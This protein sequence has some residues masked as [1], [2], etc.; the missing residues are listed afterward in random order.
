VQT[1]LVSDVGGLA[2]Q[3][4]TNLVNSWG[5]TL[6][7]QGNVRITANGTGLSTLYATDGTILPQVVTIPPPGGSPPDTTAAPNGIVLTT[8]D[9]FIGPNQPLSPGSFVFA[10]EDGTLSAWGPDFNTNTAVLTVD[11]SASN[12]VYKGLALGTN[13]QGTFLYATNFRLG[14]VDVFDQNF[15]QVQL[16]GSFSDPQLPPP[17]PGSP[18]F[19]P[20]GI[21]NIGGNLYVTYALQK[22][23]QH[24]DQAG[25]GNGFVDVFDTDGN[26]LSRFASNGTL[27][28]PWGVAQAP[29]SFGMFSGALLV[30]N[31]GDGL[32]NA[33]DPTT[34]AF[35]GQLADPNSQPI[36]IEGLWGI[37]FQQSTLFFAAGINGEADG[38]M[39][40]LNTV[41]A[42]RRANP[43][44]HSGHTEGA[45]EMTDFLILLSHFKEAPSGTVTSLTATPAGPGTVIEEQRALTSTHQL[46][47]DA[48]IRPDS[49]KAID[50]AFADFV[51]ILINPGLANG[52]ADSLA[53][54]S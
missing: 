26:L 23:D 4:D 25:P 29:D 21:Q 45:G 2:A 24:D 11:N 19:A 10:T 5:I 36:S 35:L 7:N 33:F 54:A 27:N 6:D 43:S 12:S 42:S 31:F 37:T 49:R 52:A 17:S 50:R 15:N 9:F 28:S 13:A 38:L 32:I 46:M 53:V 16:T 41:N 14:T 20:F 30:G 47:D 3:T 34:G 18:G 39:G 40:T 8:S 1:N 48:S 22:P 44:S 51:P